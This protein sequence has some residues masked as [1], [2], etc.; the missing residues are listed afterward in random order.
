[1]NEQATGCPNILKLPIGPR[2]PA[3]IRSI[4]LRGR[5]FHENQIHFACPRHSAN[6]NASMALDIAEKIA[7]IALIVTPFQSKIGW[8]IIVISKQYAG[9]KHW[10]PAPQ[11]GKN[12]Q[13]PCVVHATPFF[14]LL[15]AGRTTSAEIK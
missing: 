11:N 5:S 14:I 10:Q 9:R 12:G 2:L 1:M 8:L 3:S 13:K 15:H 6:E 7:M 4:S